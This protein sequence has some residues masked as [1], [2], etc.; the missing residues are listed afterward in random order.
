MGA[1]LSVYV[2][3]YY[4]VIAAVFTLRLTAKRAYASRV[5]FANSSWNT[6]VQIIMDLCFMQFS[7]TIH[8]RSRPVPGDDDDDDDRTGCFPARG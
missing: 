5:F 7:I 6:Q 1:Y 3:A 2:D 8:S 4:A